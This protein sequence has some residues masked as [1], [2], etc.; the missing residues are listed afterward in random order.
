MVHDTHAIAIASLFIYPIKS[1][2][3]VRVDQL[4][5]DQ[6]GRITG[7]REWAVVDA[8]S[9]IVWQG[10]HPRLALVQPNV[11]QAVLTL[12]SVACAHNSVQAEPAGA[13]RE[14][15]IWNEATSQHDSLAA[16][17]CGD[18]A[19]QLL[20]HVAGSSL[21]LV[22]LGAQAQQRPGANAVHVVSASSLAEFS[23]ALAGH[24]GV[25]GASESTDVKAAAIDL[26]T[27]QRLRPNII[28][29]GLH[30]PLVPFIEEHFTQMR[31]QS[32]DHTASLTAFKPCVRCIVPN[33]H[34]ATAVAAD[35]PLETL[36]QLSAQRHPGKPIYF[37]VYATPS[38]AAALSCD[39]ILG[40]VL[41]L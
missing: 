26:T 27:I 21:R 41:S 24:S 39:S 18:A 9:E 3:G 1:C 10:S 29:T 16:Q 6:H 40:A 2:A 5:F 32:G 33:V 13:P 28:V 37:G 4:E 23:A 38:G 34:P 8:Q 22:R 30:E 20:S 11:E 35:G 14:V 31:W 36:G 25:A 19:A 15:K 17:D 12:H 7:D